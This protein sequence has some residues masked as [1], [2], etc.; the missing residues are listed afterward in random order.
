MNRVVKVYYN[1][2]YKGR[3]FAFNPGGQANL[4]TLSMQNASHDYENVT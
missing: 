2:H 4:G 1:N 3:D